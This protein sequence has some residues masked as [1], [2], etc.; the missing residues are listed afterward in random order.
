MTGGEA[1]R[2]PPAGSAGMLLGILGKQ[3]VESGRI[4]AQLTGTKC[5][6]GHPREAPN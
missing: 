5:L 3:G 1:T 6:E 4:S 2:L